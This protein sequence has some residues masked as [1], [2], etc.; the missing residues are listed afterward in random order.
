MRRLIAILILFVPILIFARIGG[1]DILFE[2]KGAK[3]VIFSHDYHYKELGF[4]CV[5]CHDK[6]FIN[7]QK[8]KRFTMKEIYEGKSCGACHNGDTAFDPKKNCSKCHKI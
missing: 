5:D 4:E 7:K 6:I 8:D 1:G 2:V 3:N